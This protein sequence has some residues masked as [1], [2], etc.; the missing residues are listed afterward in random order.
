MNVTSTALKTGSKNQESASDHRDTVARDLFSAQQPAG[1]RSLEPSAKSNGGDVL[2]NRST[3][4]FYFALALVFT[5]FSMIHQI[6]EYLLHVHLYLLYFMGLPVIIGIL[7][8]GGL[9][10]VFKYRPAVYWTAFAL[11]LIPAALFSTW[12]GG[13]FAE[14]ATYYRTEFIMLFAIS[15]LVTRWRQCRQ[16]IYTIAFAALVNMASVMLWGRLDKGGRTS[17][18]F[19]TVANSNDYA[20]HLI[21]VLP[22]LLWIVLV[23]KSI[24]VRIAGFIALALGT[25]EILASA[26]RGA[27]L[28]LV[29]AIVVFVFTAS[30]KLR[31]AILFIAPAVVVLAMTLLPSAVVH[32]IFSFSADSSEDSTDASVSLRNRRQLLEDSIRFT[33]QNP[34]FGV[35]PAQFSTNEGTQTGESGKRFRLWYE[36]HNSFL[37]I[38]S[39]DGIPALIFYIGGILSSLLLL[40]KT[41]RLCRGR[42]DLNEIATAI[43]CLRIALI[44][45]CATIFFVNFGYFFYLPMM[46]GIAIAVAAASGKLVA[47]QTTGAKT[48][49][50]KS[51]SNPF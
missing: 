17:L 43:L 14:V 26:S 35:G 11:W 10:R 3:L 48:R 22:F 42:P 32:R 15:G 45:F 7:A 50:S 23:T 49:K 38:A 21:F 44:G 37:Q 46:G 25:Y 6:L 2:R 27:A 31:R 34:L 41:G 47:D 36:T 18:L 16:L 1:S 40:N 29:A 12:R 28:G 5:R 51:V 24:R 8:T 13:S 19:G 30:S 39:E 9:R 20:G 33:V 4:A